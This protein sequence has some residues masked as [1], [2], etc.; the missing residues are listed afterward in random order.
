MMAHPTWERF[1]R[2]YC[3]V[4]SIRLRVDISRMD[5]GDEFFS[6]MQPRMQRAFAEME[7]L[8]AGA[9]ANRDEGRMVGHYWLRSPELAPTA[10]ITQAIRDTLGEIKTFAAGVHEGT[11]AGAAGERF[12][13]LLVI[14]IGGSALGPQFVCDALA[15]A[16]GRILTY[17]IDNTDPD[18]MDR[19]F[20]QIG[21][22]LAR[23]LVL[24]ITK[25][26]GTIETRNGMF[27]V[28]RWFKR[29]GL[30]FERHAVAITGEGSKL[31]LQ[32]VTE[33]WLR[34][35]PIWEWVGGRTSVLSAVGLVPA[36]LQGHDIEALLAGAS[37]CDAATRV[38]EIKVNPAAL[39]AL[40]WYSA[41]QGK[42]SKHMVLLP[43]KDRL[44]LFSKYLQQLVMESLGKELDRDG[45]VVHQG[46][47]V[48][49]NK[50]ST[51]QHAYVQQ[52]LDGPN[53]FFVTFV[54]V[55]RDC[56]GESI[57]VDPDVTSGDYLSGFLQG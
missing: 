25:S 47:T 5:F 45:R 18:G 13:H 23:T 38:A 41:G 14:G 39:L 46:L 56:D 35:F 43:Y 40:M 17:F 32:A 20:N 36:A 44:A 33:Q 34:R 57:H 26:G 30:I 19:V 53:D 48:L 24:V 16:H 9:P 2:S 29:A 6:S 10:E 3:A 55:L 27:E 8:E 37:A 21:P 7:A 15:G 51:D 54:E 22:H 28:R 12:T 49:G 42:G 4:D 11:V 1:K 31:D 52:L 50:G